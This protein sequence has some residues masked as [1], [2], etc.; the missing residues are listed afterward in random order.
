MF[1]NEINQCTLH[2]Q[3]KTS[4][5]WPSGCG[6]GTRWRCYVVVLNFKAVVFRV[7]VVF[8]HLWRSLITVKLHGLR[9]WI[10]RL[11]V[12]EILGPPT[13]LGGGRGTPLYKL[14]RCVPPQRAVQTYWKTQS[15]G[16]GL[17][18]I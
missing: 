1:I 12:G 9:D 4:S 13:R 10:V 14:Y 11:F 3:S 15:D 5:Y 16:S 17:K 6:N 18:T 8:I 2:I 7:S